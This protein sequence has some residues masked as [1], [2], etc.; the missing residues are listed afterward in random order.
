MLPAIL[1]TD[2]LSKIMKRKNAMLLEK[3][4][5]YLMLYGKYTISLMT[6]YEILRGLKRN[7]HLN[8]SMNLRKVA[9]GSIF[10]LLRIPLS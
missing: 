3:A 2:T 5:E 7:K 8:K 9:R 1:D 4:T 6:R 10:C